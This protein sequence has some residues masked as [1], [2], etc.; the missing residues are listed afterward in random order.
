MARSHRRSSSAVCAPA[1]R[2]NKPTT[3]S[4][5]SAGS[6]PDGACGGLTPEATDHQTRQEAGTDLTRGNPRPARSLTQPESAPMPRAGRAHAR[7]RPRGR[8][9]P[10]PSR[11]AC[12]SC[13]RDAVCQASPPERSRGSTAMTELFSGTSACYRS[14]RPGIPV[15]VA[16]ILDEAAPAGEPRRL[17]DLG[18]GTGLVVKALIN[19]FDEVVAL[20][21]DEGMIAAA[22]AELEPLLPEGAR[23][24]LQH[25]RVGGRGR[26]PSRPRRQPRDGAARPQVR[27]GRVAVSA[28]ELGTSQPGGR[29]ARGQSRARAAGEPAPDRREARGA[30]CSAAGAPTGSSATCTRA[31]SRPR[32]CSA[33]GSRNSTHG[34]ARPSTS[35]T[36]PVH[37][38]RRTSSTSASPGGA[39]HERPAHALEGGGKGC[40]GVDKKGGGT[41]GAL[42]T[43]G[44]QPGG[45]HPRTL[46][47][48]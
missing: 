27:G 37:S 41:V 21:P 12:G 6:D 8:T 23:L 25:G 18:T 19:R 33:T 3:S 48:H 2:T 44:N 26:P 28:T 24:D 43:P 1:R 47:G 14:H 42:P 4:S 31:R 35:S 38:P 22:R 5:T 40:R 11:R 30:R 20:D 34:C 13:G 9:T 39:G 7:T 32:A 46:L 29:G 17:L 16:R 15:E 36:R 10:V 45:A